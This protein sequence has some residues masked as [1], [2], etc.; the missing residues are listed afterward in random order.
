MPTL[1]E[2]LEGA[3]DSSAKAAAWQRKADKAKA[4]AKTARNDDDDD[5]YELYA[6]DAETAQGKAD[7][8]RAAAAA[9][10]TAHDERVTK[11]ARDDFDSSLNRKIRRHRLEERL[12][13]AGAGDRSGVYRQ[14]GIDNSPD[15]PLWVL[16]VHDSPG[17]RDLRVD[18]PDD[19]LP[20][21]WLLSTLM[22]AHQAKGVRG[23]PGKDVML[24]GLRRL[25]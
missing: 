25:R 11:A 9:A 8:H 6:G 22:R 7:G 12:S 24:A 3:A 23:A 20:A 17:L 13:R 14:P 21:S 4:R 19:T 15:T 16:V 1:D 10:Y 18:V 2:V 5:A